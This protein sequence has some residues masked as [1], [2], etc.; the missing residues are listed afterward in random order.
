MLFRNN[1][2]D[3]T[4]RI[5]KKTVTFNAAGTLNI[6]FG[7]A[8]VNIYGT[9]QPGNPNVPGTP[10]PAQP[11]NVSG[12]NPPQPGNAAQFNPPQPFGPQPG[13]PAVPG[14]VNFQYAVRSTGN[15]P[16]GNGTIGPPLQP[17]NDACS[18]RFGPM[19]FQWYDN[20][21][22]DSSGNPLY[23]Q[24]LGVAN[25]P[26]NVPY[27]ANT[28]DTLAPGSS[29]PLDQP[30]ERFLGTQGAVTVPG[31]NFLQIPPYQ[32]YVGVVYNVNSVQPPQ[33]ATNPNPGGENPG[34]AAQ[35]N[36][37]TPGNSNFNP[38]VPNPAN[39][40]TPGTTGQPFTVFGVNFPGGPV[41]GNAPSVSGTPVFLPYLNPNDTSVSINI[42]TGGSVTITFD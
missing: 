12:S 34:N 41:A 13:S 16:S 30:G 17:Y 35:F 18:S 33:P 25:Q 37:P 20:S 29:N 32:C 24:Q 7:K 4:W 31:I 2:R 39:N 3:K 38:P 40:P 21:P 6:P 19:S 28:N 5:Q 26:L 42:P 27:P 15:S 1:L 8:V 23:F 14:S 36:P 10:T 22:G 11:G 9:G